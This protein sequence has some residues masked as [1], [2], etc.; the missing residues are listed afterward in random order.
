MAYNMISCQKVAE[1]TQIL[2]I[3]KFADVNLAPDLR[4]H[5]KKPKKQITQ[6]QFTQIF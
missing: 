4:N 5:Q 1:S 3:A 6:S 2:R